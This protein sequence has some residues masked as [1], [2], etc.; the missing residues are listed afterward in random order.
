MTRMVEYDLNEMKL[1]NG[2]NVSKKCAYKLIS[3]GKGLKR[4]DGTV[5]SSVSWKSKTSISTFAL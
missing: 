1:C 5:K 3:N 4:P 2:C